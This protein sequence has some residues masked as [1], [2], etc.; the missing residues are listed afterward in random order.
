[1]IHNDVYEVYTKPTIL[2]KPLSTHTMY[3]SVTELTMGNEEE[4]RKE[5]G[6]FALIEE[7]TI[8]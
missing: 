4:L 2:T 6:Y 1:M 7:L 5:I 8:T 3:K